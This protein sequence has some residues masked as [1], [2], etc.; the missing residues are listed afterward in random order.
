MNSVGDCI[1]DQ[2]AYGLKYKRHIGLKPN[3][4][5]LASPN[6]FGASSE[7]VRSWIEAEIWPI[8]Q[9]A[10]S[11]LARASRFAAKFRYAS[12]FGAGSEPA[13]VMEFGF[14]RSEKHVVSDSAYPRRG[15]GTATSKFRTEISSDF[16]ILMENGELNC[17]CCKQTGIHFACIHRVSKNLC[18]I[19]FVIT[20]SNFQQF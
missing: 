16:R 12:C 2:H 10:S 6:M 18:K 13:S 11:E 8:I 9:L 3:S 15:H 5:M 7:L 17:F 4:I 19:V 1:A 14:Y 20:S